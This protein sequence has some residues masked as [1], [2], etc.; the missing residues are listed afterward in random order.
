MFLPLRVLFEVVLIDQLIEVRVHR[1]ELLLG[2]LNFLGQ[3]IRLFLQRFLRSVWIG[4]LGLSCSRQKGVCDCSHLFVEL[5]LID[6]LDRCLCFIENI[7]RKRFSI[8]CEGFELLSLQ[9]LCIHGLSVGILKLLSQVGFLLGSI[10]EFRRC[11]AHIFFRDVRKFLLHRSVATKF[12]F[13]E[14]QQLFG[15]V[16]CKFIELIS[17]LVVVEQILGLCEQVV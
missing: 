5:L 7:C 16:L 8:L 15:G 3:L 11:I 17:F 9:R 14:L 13:Q 12:R 10:L 1:T 6:P 2:L 4:I